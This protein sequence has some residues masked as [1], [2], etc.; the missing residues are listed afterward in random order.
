MFTNTFGGVVTDKNVVYKY[1]EKI[2]G[3]YLR[4]IT[5]ELFF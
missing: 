4:K 3:I 5:K 2:A 1:S